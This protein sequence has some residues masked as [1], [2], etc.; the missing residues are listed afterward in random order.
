MF[1]QV[2]RLL[3]VLSRY[4]GTRFIILGTRRWIVVCSTPARLETGNLQAARATAI[5]NSV[6][7]E[8][9]KQNRSVVTNRSENCQA[10][11]TYGEGGRNNCDGDYRTGANREERVLL[12]VGAAYHDLQP[13]PVF[14]TTRRGGWMRRS[15]GPCAGPLVESHAARRLLIRECIVGFESRPPHLE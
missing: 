10:T 8:N 13:A 9:Q 15:E 12:A 4:D 2:S 3:T 7:R 11:M 14:H 5:R 6:L 1:V